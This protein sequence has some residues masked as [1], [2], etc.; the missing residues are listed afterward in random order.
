[1][2]LVRDCCRGLGCVRGKVRR[3]SESMSGESLGTINII[4]E[5]IVF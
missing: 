3:G 4:H 1:M 2:G 5:V